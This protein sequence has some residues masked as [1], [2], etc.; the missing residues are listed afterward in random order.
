MID[1]ARGS[2]SGEAVKIFPGNEDIWRLLIAAANQW[3]WGPAGM[4]AGLDMAVIA[5]MARHFGIRRDQSFFEKLRAYEHACM[6][7]WGATGSGTCTPDEKEH[8]K[9][10]FGA[11]F[12]KACEQC[13]KK[14]KK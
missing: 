13:P 4:P 10:E 6:E 14:V 9:I 3:R 11:Y 5:V 8:C 1:L 7:C 12:E 2:C